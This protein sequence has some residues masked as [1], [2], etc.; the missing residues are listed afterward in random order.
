MYVESSLVH[1]D[2]E[3]PQSTLIIY[4]LI[5]LPY[6]MFRKSF[7][8]IPIPKQAWCHS[9]LTLDRTWK[10]PP[11]PNDRKKE[12]ADEYRPKPYERLVVRAIPM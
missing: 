9:Q 4:P 6:H 7:A 12:L 3:S 11:L 5:R 1:N 10:S 2:A 8:Y